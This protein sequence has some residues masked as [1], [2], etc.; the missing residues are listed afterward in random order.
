[1]E[2]ICRI[3]FNEYFWTP[4][5]FII[6]IIIGVFEG[7]IASKIIKDK[8]FN[9]RII[10]AILISNIIGYFAQYYFSI[11]LNGGYHL[12]VW[13]PWIKIIREYDLFDYIISFPLIL[14][15]TILI[16]SFCNWII[17]RKFYK[18]RLILKTTFWINI[19]SWIILIIV[20]N[21][22]VFNVIEGQKEPCCIDD[23][24]IKLIK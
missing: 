21:C 15:V 10:L 18:G 13:I 3:N 1:M 20:I 7:A 8:L 9:T 19:M 14:T 24:S 17:L 2:N 5:S 22:I 4:Y 16:E 12:F 6:L 23:F 11:L